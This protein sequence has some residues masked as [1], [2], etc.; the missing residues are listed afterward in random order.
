MLHLLDCQA[1]WLQCQNL[2]MCC[3]FA[4]QTMTSVRHFA[5]GCNAVT[6]HPV[7]TKKVMCAC[8][9]SQ[10]NLHLH[11]LRSPARIHDSG[12]SEVSGIDVEVNELQS[13]EDGT[14]QRAVG[15]GQYEHIPTQLVLE[16]IGYMSLPLV[17]APFDTSTGTIP[18]RYQDLRYALSK[19]TGCL[20]HPQPAA[21]CTCQNGM[22]MQLLISLSAVSRLHQDHM[23]VRGASALPCVH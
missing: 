6:I 11:F 16:S 15:L 14:Q 23:F 2:K 5:D 22:T 3:C 17:G 7:L 12:T 4:S 19:C 10:R 20:Q 8:S 21:M 18:N 13:S 9:G 1:M